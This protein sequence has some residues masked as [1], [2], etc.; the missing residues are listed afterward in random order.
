MSW[1]GEL[2]INYAGARSDDSRREWRFLGRNPALKQLA[3][4][5]H[6]KEVPLNMRGLQWE[7]GV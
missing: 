4:V 2:P 3:R 1:K 5:E 7:A 6:C